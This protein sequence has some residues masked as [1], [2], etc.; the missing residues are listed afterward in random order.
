M[1]SECARGHLDWILG[2]TSPWKEQVSPG[3]GKDG[4]PF[5]GGIEK[6]CGC[7]TWGQGGLGSP[8][9]TVGLHGLRGFFHH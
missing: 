4:I 6:P 1:A 2:N 9:G 3:T 5:L 7:G 8:G